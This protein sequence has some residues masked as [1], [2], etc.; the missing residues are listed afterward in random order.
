MQS[1]WPVQ[2]SLAGAL[3]SVLELSLLLLSVRY[4]AGIGLRAV[5]LAVG[6]WLVMEV[7]WL[8]LGKRL[9]SDD[10]SADPRG[11]PPLLRAFFYRS[12][13]L[14]GFASLLSLLLTRLGLIVEPLL[15]PSIGLSVG[16]L[17]SALHVLQ[18]HSGSAGHGS[19]GAGPLGVR[20]AD[21]VIWFRQRLLRRSGTVLLAGLVTTAQLLTLL[22]VLILL[23]LEPQGWLFWRVF[24]PVLLLGEWLW[25]SSA[26]A[27]LHGIETPL[28]PLSL[29]LSSLRVSFAERESAW[30]RVVHRLLLLPSRLAMAHALVTY[31]GLG[32]A[33]LWLVQQGLLTV[34]QGLSLLGVAL[35]GE[36]TAVLWLGLLTRRSLRPLFPPASQHLSL[37]ALEA[38]RPP[39]LSVQV[40]LLLSTVLL[41]LTFLWAPVELPVLLLLGSLGCLVLVLT[42]LGLSLLHRKLLGRT[43]IATPLPEGDPAQQL[44]AWLSEA[45]HSV[46]GRALLSLKEELHMRLSSAVEAQALLHSEVEQQTLELRTQREELQK[47]L[48]SLEKTQSQ[49]LQSER[50]ASV[51]RLIAN[52][53]HEINNPV[54]A[55]LNSGEPLDALLLD[56]TEKLRAGQT[57]SVDEV[58]E[59]L[60]D[61]A[62]MLKV[63]E[64]GAERTRAIAVGLHRYSAEGERASDEVDLLRCLED[65]LQLLP[66]LSE[67]RMVRAL[68][69]LPP[70]RGHAGQLQQVLA[71]LL[72]NARF[73]MTQRADVDPTLTLRSRVLDGEV[74]LEVADNGIGMSEEVRRRLF[75]PFFTTKDIAHGTGLGLAIAHGIIRQHHG[76]IVVS[77]QPGQGSTFALHLP[78]ASREPEAR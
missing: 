41:G 45:E 35:I 13:L 58:H 11:G 64:R 32:L 10:S 57:L 33:M 51:G 71:N 19:L 48:S 50:L 36:S 29:G 77:S 52:V 34:R 18:L 17:L 24:A 43:W 69:P 27:L 73:A 61:S 76:R 42:A 65:A 63:M 15:L 25:L 2:P 30:L 55:V 70:V 62:A 66:G 8:Q 39:P 60:D 67:L 26:M 56:A 28:V 9:A 16:P 6:L 74:V 21:P 4:L 37:S 23:W 38:L 44:A 46:L 53:T 14:A 78:L 31:V 49:L 12:L 72:D 59:L 22:T 68:S 7:L 20:R 1:A 5:V 75:E 54:N 47:A 3:F 40:L